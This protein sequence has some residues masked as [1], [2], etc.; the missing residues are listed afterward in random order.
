M[1]PAY[2]NYVEVNQNYSPRNP[3]NLLGLEKIRTPKE[4][5][6]ICLDWEMETDLESHWNIVV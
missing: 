5:C 4:L 1:S 2:S 3:F 6:E